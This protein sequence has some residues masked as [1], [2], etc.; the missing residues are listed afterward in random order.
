MKERLQSP[1]IRHMTEVT[2]EV[3]VDLHKYLGT[4]EH[5]AETELTASA[6]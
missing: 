6:V 4:S 5:I 3:D 2:G 1:K